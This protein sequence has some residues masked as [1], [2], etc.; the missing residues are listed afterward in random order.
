M[1]ATANPIPLFDASDA[2]CFV[3]ATEMSIRTAR[4]DGEPN[5]LNHATYREARRFRRTNYRC[6]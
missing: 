4:A 3:S 5:D 1:R 2:T 6:F